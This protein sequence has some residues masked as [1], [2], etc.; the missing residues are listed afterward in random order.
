MKQHCMCGSSYQSNSECGN[1]TTI[2][3]LRLFY[4]FYPCLYEANICVSVLLWCG[5][6]NSPRVGELQVML[7]NTCMYPLHCIVS[8][9][10][11][12]FTC[13]SCSKLLQIALNYCNWVV[14]IFTCICENVILSVDLTLTSKVVAMFGGGGGGANGKGISTVNTEWVGVVVSF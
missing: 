8:L 12:L 11:S 3:F 6:C 2:D 13:P 14:S 5:V 9:L 7:H 10:L 4:C 1:N